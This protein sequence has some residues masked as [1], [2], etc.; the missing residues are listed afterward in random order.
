[1]SES[2]TTPASA[3]S[4]DQMVGRTSFRLLLLLY[5]PWFRERFGEEIIAEFEASR[6]K[7]PTEAGAVAFWIHIVR[8]FITTVP[9]AWSHT[10]LSRPS[11][12]P[13]PLAGSRHMTD[14]FFAD[15]RLAFRGLI[16]RPGA[17][18]IA[19]VAL[20]LG[21]GLTTGMFSIVSGTILK[22]LPVEDP[23]DIMAVS[24]VN[25]S[26]GPNR[27][28]MRT[29]DFLDL[30]ERQ[31]A[32]E[33]LG[34]YDV[35]SFNLAASGGPPEFISGAYITPNT[36]RLLRTAPVVGR[37]L[38]DADAVPGAPNVALIGHDFWQARFDGATDVIGRTVR[39]DGQPT[40]IVG[41]MPEGFE[42]PINQRLW[43]PL[44]AGPRSIDRGAG[45]RLSAFGRL[46]RTSVEGAENDLRRIMA[47][48]S[49]EYPET[50]EGITVVVA[51]YVQE[52]VGYQMPGVLFTMLAAVSLVL[53]IACA[54]VANLLLARA[55]LRS[56]EV[57]LKTALGA[58]RS[59]VV[60]QLLVDS[61]AIAL[62][63]AGLGIG[64]AEIAIRAF[65]GSLASF[66]QGVPYWFAIELDTAVLLFVLLLT[67][68]ASLLSGVIPAVRAS[69]TDVNEILKDTAR[70]SASLSIG[71]FSR[72]LVIVQVALSFALLV[73][74]GLMVKSVTNLA[75]V[76][77]PF[78]GE[79]VLTAS[80]ILPE[81]TYPGS[82]ERLRFFEEL[83]ARLSSEPDV[84]ST[85]ITTDLPAVG[86]GSGRLEVEGETYSG[87]NDYPRVRVGS[88]D[89][90][91]F[92]TVSA[93]LLEGRAFQS[94]DDA[95]SSLV[96]IVNQRFTDQF[97][98]GESPL[99][100]RVR[101]RRTSRADAPPQD[102][103]DWYTIVGLAPD[104]YLDVDAFVLPP[105]A[106]YI[107]LSQRNASTVSVMVHTRGDPL[108]FTSRTRDIV[109]ELDQDLPI[110]QVA[111]LTQAIRSEMLLFNIFGVMF[112][113]FGGAALLL[114][115]VGLYGVVSFSVNQ[116]RRD[117]G[118]RIALGASSGRIVRLVLGQAGFQLATGIGVGL[119]LSVLLGQGLAFVLFGVEAADPMV[120]LTVAAVLSLTAVLACLVP[121]GRAVGVDPI[122]A[123][124]SE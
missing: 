25:P 107:P 56:K 9:R 110:S 48:L 108:G 11:F 18:L 27:L 89:P 69:R 2:S 13:S 113:V 58:S 112:T 28:A 111:T 98:K 19:I 100:R 22:G 119:G 118:L 77:Y 76:A 24:R 37:D 94:S 16:R 34:A 40:E 30:G 4:S 39:V 86:S 33:G 73:S 75:N 101:L 62:L 74:A 123:L 1:M 116:R 8:D 66:P 70:G 124:Q 10:L 52:V 85:S 72:G 3:G 83:Q 81:A 65:N 49:L 102:V 45:P 122:V 55:S 53:L 5:P 82:G 105:E 35:A 26:Q 32:F 95:G 90:T 12:H 93:E 117:L 91:Y 84:I 51:P 36:F 44:P 97:L 31:T 115:S 57:A 38:T 99:G 106:I 6:A 7:S 23:Q 68:G 17:A 104:F 80:L 29:S 54:N 50:N 21:I 78:E 47:Q 64:V 121:A 92:E 71:R 79:N 87:E 46:D 109:A 61:S 88:I 120:L 96:A 114:A 42:F 41:I 43:R 20:G 59:R 63:G 60:F 67:V 14:N 103:L 15:I